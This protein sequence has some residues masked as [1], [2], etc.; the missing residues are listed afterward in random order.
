MF[1][2]NGKIRREFLKRTAGA[3]AAVTAVGAPGAKAKPAMAADVPRKWNKNT[4]VVVVGAGFCGLTACITA[5]NPRKIL[6]LF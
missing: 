3:D 5:G 4:D 1:T 6:L 2:V